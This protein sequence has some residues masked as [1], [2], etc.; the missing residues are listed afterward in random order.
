MQQRQSALVLVGVSALSV[1]FGAA[2]ATRLFD[3]VG[4][5]G[6]ATL[7][8][9][10]AALVLAVL[11]RPHHLWPARQDLA[12][13]AAFGLTMA[14]MN[15]TFYEAIARIPLGV[16]VTV[17][18]VGPL[19]VTFV[20]SRRAAHV[21]WAALAGAGV[22]LLATGGG[23]GVDLV[24]IAMALLAGGCWAAYI[25]LSKETGQRFPGAAGLAV[26]M[27]VAAVAVL[28]FGLV[29]APAR[30]FTPSTLALGAVVAVLSSAIP[31]SLE[32]SALRRV[33]SRSF[34]VLLSLDP[35]VAALIGLVVL[36]QHLSWRELLALVLVVVANAGNALVGEADTSGVVPD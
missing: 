1:Q 17:E 35:A 33:S 36:G 25:V 18:F 23:H 27:I 22:V 31:Y 10:I 20:G 15:V 24:G 28:P 7:R 12:V 32:L 8:L 30:L 26:A 4:P 5:T 2:L 34:G 13:V 16:A 29:S 11:L 6:A 9:V 3:K 19:A 21:V 14:A